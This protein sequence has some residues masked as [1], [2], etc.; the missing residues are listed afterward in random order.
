MQIS[1]SNNQFYIFHD[2]QK[3]TIYFH[4]ILYVYEKY[5]LLTEAIECVSVYKTIHIFI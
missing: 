3:N 1:A 4:I 5:F 2:H